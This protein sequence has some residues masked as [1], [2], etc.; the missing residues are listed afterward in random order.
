MAKKRGR[1]GPNQSEFIREL[2]KQNP[3]TKLA[4]AKAAW[5]EAGYKGA[6]GNSLFYV[7]KR[8]AGMTKPTKDGKRRGRPP[9]SANRPKAIGHA[10]TTHAAYEAAEASL[11]EVIRKLWDAGDH[12]TAIELIYIRRR[13]SAKLV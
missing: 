3:N 8:K 9:G 2:F 11:D 10:A 6:I 7:V 4:D 5:T 1:G 13:I 12:E